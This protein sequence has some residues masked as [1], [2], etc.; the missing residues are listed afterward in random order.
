MCFEDGQDLV[1][2]LLRLNGIDNKVTVRKRKK[3]SCA[4]LTNYHLGIALTGETDIAISKNTKEA[5]TAVLKELNEAG[6][7]NRTTYE[8][9]AKIQL[10]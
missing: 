5:A 8:S 1:E 2:G 9:E 10:L 4:L 3:K 6:R 7:K